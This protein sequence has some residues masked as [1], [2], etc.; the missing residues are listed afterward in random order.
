M[1]KVKDYRGE[2]DFSINKG[3]EYCDN[4]Q[5][6]AG[7]KDSIGRE[8]NSLVPLTHSTSIGSMKP[9]GGQNKFTD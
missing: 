7:A 1:P 4:E 8:T 5:L 3:V 2:S 6:K 9:F